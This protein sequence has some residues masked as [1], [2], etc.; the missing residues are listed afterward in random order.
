[1]NH[2]CPPKSVPSST[3][4]PPP[5]TRERR[6]DHTDAIPLPLT[7]LCMWVLGE[8]YAPDWEVPSGDG[9]RVP[10]ALCWRHARDGGLLVGSVTACTG[11]GDRT[12]TLLIYTSNISDPGVREEVELY[13]QDTATSSLEQ[14]VIGVNVSDEPTIVP[15]ALGTGYGTRVYGFKHRSRRSYPPD[16]KHYEPEHP[17]EPLEYMYQVRIVFNFDA[18][19]AISTILRPKLSIQVR[20]ASTPTA[21][22]QKFPVGHYA[23]TGDLGRTLTDSPSPGATANPALVESPFVII[24]N[25]GFSVGD[26]LRG[27]A[28]QA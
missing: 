6:Q 15:A 23:A 11:N 8:S 20:I 27:A 17:D 18:P 24:I 22:P 16:G 10:L 26:S 13:N 7:R 2:H 25:I 5:G 1:M 28:G 14:K 9:A 21:Q 4:L 12:K 3:D 19:D